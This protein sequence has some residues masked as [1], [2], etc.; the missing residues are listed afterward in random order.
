MLTRFEQL[1]LFGSPDEHGSHM[2][3]TRLQAAQRLSIS[4]ATFD[5][6]RREGVIPA[7][8]ESI[9]TTPMVWDKDAIDRLITA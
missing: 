5:R 7:P 9:R 4:P 3:Y 8:L 1:L 2:T 6:R